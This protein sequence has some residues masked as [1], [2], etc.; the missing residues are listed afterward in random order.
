MNTVTRVQILGEAVRIANSANT[1]RKVKNPP[2]FHP[3]M[4][5]SAKQ[6]RLI[7]LTT[8]TGLG[9][10]KSLNSN[11][12]KIDLVS[13]PARRIGKYVHVLQSIAE[14]LTHPSIILSR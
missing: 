1:H 10:G 4:G 2:I 7:D 8:A 6:T 11:L 14:L 3:A 12:L 5:K 9:E 13:H